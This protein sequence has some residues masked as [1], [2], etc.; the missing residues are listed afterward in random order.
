MSP[1]LPFPF[2]FSFPPFSHILLP[3]RLSSSPLP[4]LALAHSVSGTRYFTCRAPHGSFV[5]PDKVVIGDFPEEEIDLDMDE[6]VDE[7]M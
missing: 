5:R 3:T 6:D 2:P 1:S 7:E 4:A